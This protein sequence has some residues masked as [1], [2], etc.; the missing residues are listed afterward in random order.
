MRLLRSTCG[1]SLTPEGEH[2]LGQCQ[3]IVGDLKEAI[4]QVAEAG[5]LK[6]T[7]RLAS[8]NDFRRA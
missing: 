3:S 6:G 1:L 8:I 7:I 2:I 5:W 4:D